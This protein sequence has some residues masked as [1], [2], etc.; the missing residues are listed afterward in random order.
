MSSEP[1]LFCSCS[2]SPASA[3]AVE[4]MKRAKDEL[5]AGR[6][7][8]SLAEEAAAEFGKAFRIPNGAFVVPCDSGADAV[9]Y[10][11][12]IVKARHAIIPPSHETG[13]RI[14]TL[15]AELG[16]DPFEIHSIDSELNP[17]VPEK[18]SESF[19]EKIL[20]ASQKGVVAAVITDQTKLGFVHPVPKAA[21]QA[22][23]SSHAVRIIVDACQ[24]RI[25]P[26]LLASYLEAGFVV[27]LTGSK[28][29][30]GPGLSGFCVLPFKP[31]ILPQISERAALDAVGA[32]AELR[33]FDMAL[34]EEGCEFL[35]YFEASFMESASLF[36]EILPIGRPAVDRTPFLD[37][38]FDRVRTIFPFVALKNGN[39]ISQSEAESI[40]SSLESDHESKR[41]IFLGK[42]VAGAF[43]I[44]VGLRNVVD[45]LADP[46][47]EADKALFAL[48]SVARLV[49]SL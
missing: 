13:R 44:A 41:R 29:A 10:A 34:S 6:P 17:V 39:R 20:E 22:A 15:L 12:S 36:Q 38:P 4:A 16:I 19:V 28:F 33:S 7:I 26:T 9:A 32:V 18:A 25:S 21:F 14:S 27:C 49:Q 11:S 37:E 1:I 40:R 2:G 35:S 30:M 43:R 47:A 24:T 8:S 42:N 46:E 48:G 45:G 31:E 5:T 23:E 3:K